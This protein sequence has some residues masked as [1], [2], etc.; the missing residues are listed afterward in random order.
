MTNNT[1]NEYGAS[2]FND[3]V[4][5]IDFHFLANIL[6][7]IWYNNIIPYILIIWSH[8]DTYIMQK[9]RSLNN[10]YIRF[11]FILL[12]VICIA[13]KDLQFA[14]TCLVCFLY[15]YNDQFIDLVA[16]VVNWVILFKLNNWCTWIFVY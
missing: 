10:Y 12:F 9:N 14:H 6:E 2:S 8:I 1:T 4:S 11:F 16:R 3:T 13:S 15:C 7:Q 5:E